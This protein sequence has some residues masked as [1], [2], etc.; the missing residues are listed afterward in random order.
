MATTPLELE[1]LWWGDCRSTFHEEQKQLV[2][3]ERMGLRPEWNCGHPPQ[4]DVS[5]QNIV[6]IGGGPVSLLLKARNLGSGTVWDPGEYPEWVQLRYATAGI[7]YQ[8]RQG[9]DLVTKEGYDEAW[10]YNCL[11]HVEDPALVVH[12]A[13]RAAKTIRFFEWI[14]FAAYEG[15]PH[16]L[17]EIDLNRWLGA[18]G[19]VAYVNENGA[20]GLAYYGVFS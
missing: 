9:E 18:T 16:E 6:D 7:V 12:N 4:F 5:G 15:H 2:Y 8:Q 1:G 11:Q 20:E 10:V 13:R 19:F 3:A 17:S 14:G